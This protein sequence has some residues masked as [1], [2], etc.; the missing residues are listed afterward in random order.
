MGV[1]VGACAKHLPWITKRQLEPRIVDLWRGSRIECPEGLLDLRP[2]L[3]ELED[4]ARSD[5]Q[6]DDMSSI[7]RAAADFPDA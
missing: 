1:V 7:K 5:R 6:L 2:T 4:S 3:D